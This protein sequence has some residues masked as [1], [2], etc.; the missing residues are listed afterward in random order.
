MTWITEQKGEPKVITALPRTTD[1]GFFAALNVPLLRGRLF[2]DDDRLDTPGVVVITD[3][4]ARAAWPGEDPIGKRMKMG[5]ESN[6]WLTVV[7]VVGDV[8]T[9]VTTTPF[10]IVYMPYTQSP[11]FQPQ[12]VVIRTRVDPSSLVPAVREVVHEIDKDLP[13]ADLR[14]MAEVMSA[15]TSR[16]RFNLLLMG[17]FAALAIVMAGV[18]MY[19]VMAYTVAHHTREIGIRMALGARPNAIFKLIIGH[20]L[21]LA[22]IGVVLGVAGG[23]ALTRLMTSLLFEVKANDP[24]TFIVVSIGAVAVAFV[25][26]Y[27]PAR[28]A[29]KVDPLAALRYE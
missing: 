1:A 2:N 21:V 25:A 14:T 5:I 7:G 26:C 9:L 13:V 23:L 28:R 19:G 27:V 8:R 24:A 18:G 20:G 12:D 3:R 10:Q 16:Q 4:M 11:D 29:M 22:T 15:A 6:P 17:F